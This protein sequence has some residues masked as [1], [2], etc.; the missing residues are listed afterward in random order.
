MSESKANKVIQ[1]QK[2]AFAEVEQGSSTKP[3]PQSL[4]AAKPKNASD[5]EFSTESECSFPEKAVESFKKPKASPED[6]PWSRD[7]HRAFV[8][9]VFQTGVRQ[10]SPSVLLENMDNKAKLP[11][12]TEKLKSRLQKY[13]NNSRKSHSEFMQE[14]DSWIAKAHTVGS[15]GGPAPCVDPRTLLSMMGVDRVLGAEVAALLSYACMEQ[16]ERER[17]GESSDS[18]SQPSSANA[19][20]STR[21]TSGAPQHQSHVSAPLLSPVELLSGSHDFN[22]YF[23][24]SEIRLPMLTPNERRSPLGQSMSHVMALFYSLTHQLMAVRAAKSGGTVEQGEEQFERGGKQQSTETSTSNN[25]IDERGDG[26]P[27][28]TVDRRSTAADESRTLSLP[29]K[30]GA[31]LRAQQQTESS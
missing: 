21:L 8:E 10:A 14:Y 23:A 25:T 12:T 30:K 16:D 1:G 15:C 11:L 19:T 7:I 31:K 13:R 5:D 27:H 4:S 9:A 18:N 3:G 28:D 17:K 26:K 2:R 29:P 24:G 6:L 22:N 20:A